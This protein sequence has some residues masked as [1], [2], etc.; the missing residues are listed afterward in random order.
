MKTS[1]QEALW[2][3]RAQ[4][5][6]LEALDSLLEGVQG[7]LFRLI[8]GIVGDHALSEDVLQDVLVLVCRKL[9]WLREPRLFH[10]WAFRIASR[11]AIRCVRRERRWRRQMVEEES[12][13]EVADNTP[14]PADFA[15][16][17]AELP[18]LV[19]SVPPASRAVLLLHYQ[20]E[21]SLQEV[22][23]VL[24]LPLGTAKSRLAYGLS[25]L[26]SKK[27]PKH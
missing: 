10:S 22:A 13:E 7:S 3:L 15:V 27:H 5:G 23:D 14:S 4:S 2:I 20:E 25:I 9:K 21:H 8:R 26:R 11:E 12:L 6:D 19:E 18:A 1:K 24:G 17:I 16:R